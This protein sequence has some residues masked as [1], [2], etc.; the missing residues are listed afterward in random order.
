M[1][2]PVLL[3]EVLTWL[4]PQ[5]GESYLDATAG[6]GGHAGAIL[7]VTGEYKTSVLVDRDSEAIDYLRAKF[8]NSGVRILKQNFYEAAKLLVDEGA[9]FNL[10][11]ADLGV[12]S[13][14]L[15]TASRGFSFNLAGPLDMRMDQ[16]QELTAANIVNEWTPEQLEQ[17]IREYG[18][19]PQARK[20]VRSLVAERP[21]ETTQQLAKAIAR[22]TGKWRGKHPATRTFQ[23]IRI[24]VNQELELLAASLPL[25]LNILRP[26]GRLAVISFHS[27]EDRIVKNFFVENGQNIYDASLKIL[28]KNPVMASK[29][30]IDFNPRAR[31]AKLRAAAKINNRKDQ[32]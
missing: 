10:I 31:S 7:E 4:Q 21:F 5:K 6:Y 26:G 8:A 3:S 24:A 2:E 1:H 32:R 12:S 11:L 18:E 28:T 15:N 23:A 25:W 30:E 19:E 14:H 20:I 22:Q 16:S 27:L 29:S 17:I 9:Q 13:L